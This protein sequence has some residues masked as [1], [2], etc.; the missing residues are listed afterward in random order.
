M[1]ENYS[2]GKRFGDKFWEMLN[3]R[4]SFRRFY[5]FVVYVRRVARELSTRLVMGELMMSCEFS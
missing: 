5:V 1:E 2:R 4:R 3:V